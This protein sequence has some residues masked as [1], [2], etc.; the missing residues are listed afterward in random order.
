MRLKRLKSNWISKVRKKKNPKDSLIY[1]K[2]NNFYS[3][4][5]FFC[6]EFKYIEEAI[7]LRHKDQNPQLQLF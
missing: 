4:W 6:S 2:A 7:T 1:K 5:L 3:Y